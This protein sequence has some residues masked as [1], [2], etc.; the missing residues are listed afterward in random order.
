MPELSVS[1]RSLAEFCY[2][3]GDIDHRFTPSP[4]GAEG[5]QG[6][7]RLAAERPAT[8]VAEYPLE[9]VCQLGNTRLTL[10]GRADGY[11][12]SAGL[13]EE[14]KTCRVDAPAIPDSVSRQ[15]LAQARLYAGIIAAAGDMSA[16]R[17]RLTWFNIDS[18]QQ[19]HLDEELTAAE[20]AEFLQASLLEFSAWVETVAQQRQQRDRSLAELAFPFRDF[21]AGQRDI[22]ELVYKCVDQG[23]RLLVEAP[24]GLGKTAAVLYPAL[25]ALQRGKHDRLL[26]LTAKTS[27][28][29]AAE[30]TLEHFRGAGFRGAA[31][32]ITARDRVCLSPGKAC[33]GDDCP[34]ARGYYDRRPD[35]MYEALQRPSLTR[36]DIEALAGQHQI[37]PYQLAMDLLPWVDLVIA[38][39]HYLYS[40]T[41]LLGARLQ[42]DTLRWTALLDEAHNLPGR[43]VDMYSAGLLK[44]R[45]MS[46]RAEAAGTVRKTLE[47]CN[48][49]L[50]QLQRELLPDPGQVISAQLPAG[51]AEALHALVA[52][53]GEQL[54]QQP[55]WLQA[56]PRLMDFYF[57][58]LQF[59]RVL[60]EWGE[61]YR[62]ELSRS[63]ARQS[64]K[65]RLNCLDPSRLL[66]ARHADLHALA[67]FSATLTPR[68]WMCD[69]L[70][71][72]AETVWR[73]EES[74]FDPSQLLVHIAVE[75]DTRYRQRDRT[76]PRLAATLQR[77]LAQVQGNCIVY[78]P[79]YRYL[80]GC[81]ELMPEPVPERRWVQ[82]ST[83]TEEERA[84]LLALLA[85]RNDVTAFC[86]L[87]G[88]YGEGIDLPGDLLASVVIVGLG[89][90]Q[91]NPDTEQRRDY[92]QARYGN[93]FEYAYLYP[94][95]Q[96]V[97]QAL[98]RVIRQA[99]DS[100]EA[101]LIDSRYSQPVYRQLLPPWWTYRD[102]TGGG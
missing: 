75:V 14:I 78:F 34:Y 38:D 11:D 53:V 59:L 65:L 96:K 84:R 52:V 89:L 39:V 94:G 13:V 67:A 93:G 22:A 16:L 68:Q 98:G 85:Q 49:V 95:M 76:L 9:H 4:T 72:P 64:L 69:S 58:V 21:R 57:D 12:A 73:R 1:V 79:S 100:G 10:R 35:A 20:L 29:L 15:H 17:V 31:L 87:G 25:K 99:Q 82:Q 83:Q 27:G 54:A 62:L 6:H 43:A 26:F 74:P 91:V 19:W 30:Q 55:A 61:E 32:S 24:T 41:P 81:L 33:H 56:R 90:P 47:R 7:Q 46:A 92:F 60:E 102:Y 44:D 37:C 42:D 66:A 50:L 36:E 23:G 86:I 71:L 70:G 101:L 40:L 80:Q 8:W 18:G 2:R 63:A 45:L 3:S 28:R 88:V 97:G 77:W 48:R 51:L 5:L